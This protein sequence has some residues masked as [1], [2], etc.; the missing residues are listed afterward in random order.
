[1]ELS[2]LNALIKFEGEIKHHL[3]D[4]ASI[5]TVNIHNPDEIERIESEFGMLFSN[6]H[7]ILHYTGLG[8]EFLNRSLRAT[9]RFQPIF[10]S[11]YEF[12]LNNSLMN[13]DSAND[14]IVW[15]WRI[16][17]NEFYYLK[18][19]VGKSI[20]FPCFLSTSGKK[21]PNSG[22]YFKIKTSNT[23]RGKAISF[24]RDK[25]GVEN[26]ILFMSRTVF[27]ITE[28]DGEV[29]S[30]DEIELTTESPDIIAYYNYWDSELSC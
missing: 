17:E 10:V 3:Q 1:M 25:R 20:I 26:E 29:I 30:L 14:D 23:S 28:C 21:L 6:Y 4:K 16:K 12:H 7:L 22:F 8:F 24:I 5:D 15:R 11:C 18:D 19:K 27:R 13:L 9:S 2:E